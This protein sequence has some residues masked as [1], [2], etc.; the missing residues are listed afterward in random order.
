[1]SQIKQELLEK[2]REQNGLS[3]KTSEIN[4]NPVAPTMEYVRNPEYKTK[5]QYFDTL[6]QNIALFAIYNCR[7]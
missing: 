3:N 1:M 5:G 7:R 6:K 4:K 2:T